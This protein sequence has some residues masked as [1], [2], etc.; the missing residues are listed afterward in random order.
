M[1]KETNNDASASLTSSNLPAVAQSSETVRTLLMAEAEAADM[2]QK[3]RVMREERVKQALVEADREI[4]AYR[5]SKEEAYQRALRESG[6]SLEHAS[7]A[8]QGKAEKQ[9][10]HER[11]I[12]AQRKN[13]AIAVLEECVMKC[14]WQF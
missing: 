7:A 5:S 13:E 11:A 9:M 8:M 2:I 1:V 6:G 3:A 12:A 10:A 4:A 14:D